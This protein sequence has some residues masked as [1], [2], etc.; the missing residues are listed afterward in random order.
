VF[1]Y[2]IGTSIVVR[3]MAFVPTG[4]ILPLTSEEL[5]PA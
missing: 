4:V 1:Q 5:T 3:G 2:L